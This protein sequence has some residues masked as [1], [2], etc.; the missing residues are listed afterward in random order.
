MKRLYIKDE[1]HKKLKLISVEE[2]IPMQDLTEEMV[3]DFLKRRK[4]KK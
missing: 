4:V 3:I 2:E 1:L